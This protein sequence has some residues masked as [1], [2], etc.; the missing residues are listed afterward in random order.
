MLFKIMT[1]KN[2]KTP[3]LSGSFEQVFTSHAFNYK[4]KYSQ[5]S[6]VTGC[7]ERLAPSV[8]TALKQLIRE[9]KAVKE[10]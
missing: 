4:A 2:R 1:I 5:Y 7:V 6:S 3:G 10:H 9:N 8:Y